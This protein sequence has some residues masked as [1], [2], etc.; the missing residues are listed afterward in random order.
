MTFFLFLHL[1]QQVW[2]LIRDALEVENSD[3]ICQD[4]SISAACGLSSGH[5]CDW[6]QNTIKRLFQRFSNYAC[7]ILENKKVQNS[8]NLMCFETFCLFYFI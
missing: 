4:N 2:R 8:T 6:K 1:H 5:C 3:Y 7:Y